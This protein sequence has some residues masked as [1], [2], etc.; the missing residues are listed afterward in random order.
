[1]S[2]PREVDQALNDAGF[3]R[4]GWRLVRVRGKGGR[5]G[6]ERTIRV[7][8]NVVL[9]CLSE[10]SIYGFDLKQAKQSSERWER[11]RERRRQRTCSSTHHSA[12]N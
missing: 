4:G 3:L 8:A 9:P 10:S 12:K 2:S 5:K 1:V 7:V 11:E 6:G